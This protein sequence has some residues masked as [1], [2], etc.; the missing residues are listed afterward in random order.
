MS[1]DIRHVPER[2]RYELVAD[3][4][5]IGFADYH[6]DGQALIFPHTVIG[7]AHRGKGNGDILVRGALDH[8]R[9]QGRTIVPSC[10]FVREFV[11][12]HPDYA[13]LLADR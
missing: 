3:D 10:W 12:L 5:V 8:V 11:D 6:D 13:D 4:Q 2:S 7:P 9:S 1:H